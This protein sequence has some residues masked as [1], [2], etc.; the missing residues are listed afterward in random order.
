MKN[1]NI[2]IGVIQAGI[3]YIL[4]GIFPIY[5]KLLEHVG[6][7]E[8]LANRIFWS[9]LS[10]MLFL[11]VT[12]KMPAYWAILKGFK[13]NKKQFW[14][15]VAASLLISCNWYLYIWAV[16]HDQI[17]QASLGYYINPLVS[18]L[19]GVLFLKE[20]LSPAQ[21]LSFIIAVA[22]VLILSISYGQM[23]WIALALAISFGLYGL[24]KK[25]LK[26]DS[27][28]GL[29]LETMMVTPIAFIYIIIL[30]VQGNHS[31]LA[32]SATTD[33]LLMASGVI[34]AVPL[35]YFAKGAQ[36]IPLSMLGFIQYI[37]PT[38]QLLLGVFIYG[39]HFSRTHLL[40]FMFIW[41]ALLLYTISGTKFVKNIENKRENRK[42]SA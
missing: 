41:I 5:W 10:M 30:F 21:V 19:L 7:N 9:F 8:I 38:I 12:K 39:E 32:G 18:I 15:L 23:P 27:A 42:T 26:V 6:S 37:N 36:K 17:I 11:S 33:L 35:L 4:W 2:K 1:N 34:T 29:T 22:G 14:A 31:L 24:A 13:Q 16:N 20:K 3:S 25:M 28:I 40:S